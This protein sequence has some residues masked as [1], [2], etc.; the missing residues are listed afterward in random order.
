MNDSTTTGVQA[1]YPSRPLVRATYVLMSAACSV[2]LFALPH[3]GMAYSCVAPSFDVY[4]AY[5][6]SGP[7][8]S[9]SIG[10]FNNDNQPDLMTATSLLPGDNSGTFPT[11]SSLG[12]GV[13]PTFAAYGDFDSDGNLDVA[14]L[15]F[16]GPS[17]LV[18]LADGVGGFDAPTA[19]PAGVQPI[20]VV[21]GL[22]NNDTVPDLAVTD[23]LSNQ[24]LVFLGNGD[25]SFASA[26]SVACGI[27]PLGLAV[28]DLDGNGKQD[29]VVANLQNTSISVMLGNGDGTFGAPMAAPAGDSP[30]FVVVGDF[31]GDLK[32]DVALG[33]V[34]GN[35]V[36]VLR[37][38]GAG[39]FGP[40]SDYTVETW[41]F[42]LAVADFNGDSKP[43]LA[44]ANN[45]SNTVSVLLN[46]GSGGFDPASNYGVGNAPI[47]VAAADLNNDGK[48]DIVASSSTVN[49][50]FVLLNACG[51]PIHDTVVLPVKPINV[52]IPFG[53]TSIS[54]KISVKVRNADPVNTGGYAVKLVVDDSDCGTPGDT[55][56]KP[57]FLPVQVGEQNSVTVAYGKAKT[58]KVA[59][60]ID[61]SKFTS[62]N[63]NAPHRCT[64]WFTSSADTGIPNGDPALWNNTFPVELNV[65]DRNDADQTMVHETTAVSIKFAT[66][67]IAKGKTSKTLTVLPK[68]GN[69]DAGEVAGDH[70]VSAVAAMGTCPAGIV[71]DL[72]FS[73]APD[74][75][76][77]VNVGGGLKK[78]GKLPLS[79]TAASL[80]T[81]NILSPR[82]CVAMVTATGPTSEDFD[83]TNDTTRLVIDMV[84]KTDLPGSCIP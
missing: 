59:L 7:S 20:M 61:S 56:D 78:G 54:K 3:R 28:G 47:F 5:G 22:F 24:V 32:Q 41:P 52:T 77:S 21:T 1:Y 50:V 66:L 26:T 49:S 17:L 37:G 80:C 53:K 62:F 74:V 10:D 75:Q 34:V 58:A 31:D 43:D 55:A 2:V 39:G 35:T 27:T 68:V 71:G 12:A 73:T 67:N 45:L 23:F 69:A 63:R 16:D 64:L 18:L 14:V 46:N 76:S 57:D 48:A 79:V 15:D 29:L 40:P 44:V 6:L 38:D 51:N 25:G 83:R 82:R 33:H 81:P 70:S 36:S 60:T 42:G 30:G 84:D 19:Y 9:V 11:A 65:I 8:G 72:D 13:S 4:T